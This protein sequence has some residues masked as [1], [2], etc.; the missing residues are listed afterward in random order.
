MAKRVKLDLAHNSVEYITV[1]RECRTSIYDRKKVMTRLNCNSSQ[2]Q[3]LI[4]LAQIEDAHT[5]GTKTAA[6]A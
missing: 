6:K 1:V 5:T 4:A 2:A 3:T